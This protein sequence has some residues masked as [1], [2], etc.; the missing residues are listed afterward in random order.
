MP[1]QPDAVA[2]RP[3]ITERARREQLIGLTIALI[4][5][6]GYAAT[7]L[8]SIAAAASISKAAVLYHFSSKQA[9]IEAAYRSVL[10][11]LTEHVGPRVEAAAG[12][13][14]AVEEYAAAM[15]GYMADHPDHVRVIAEAL[16]DPD[17]TGI[18]D[19]PGSAAR[20]G[21]LAALI[22]HAQDAGEYRPADARTQ[23]IMIN[24]AIDAVVAESLND[25]GYRLA[26]A[27]DSVVDLV[28]RA[29]RG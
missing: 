13:G 11:D 10:H 27:A 2:R 18:G 6:R 3:S 16:G 15:I 20:W 26:D 9:V 14:A 28:R 17:D 25:D 23:A 1:P 12:P 4:A 22:E 21:A 24:G 29:A 7:S 8:A 19:S 5:E